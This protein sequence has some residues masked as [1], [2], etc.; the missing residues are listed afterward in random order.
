MRR[1]VELLVPV[2]LA[3]GAAWPGAPPAALGTAVLAALA[4]ALAIA[5]WRL[6]ARL[7]PGARLATRLSAATVLATVLATVPATVL[8][9]FGLLRPWAFLLWAALL[10]LGASRLGGTPPPRPSPGPSEADDPRLPG[11]RAAERALAILALVV[12]ACATVAEVRA[13]RYSAPGTFGFDDLSYHLTTV[14]T[15]AERGDL[16]MVKY[17]VGDDATPYYPIASELVSWALLAPFETND[18]A[19]RWSQLPFALGA[20]AALASLGGR[21]GM[22]PRSVLPALVLFWSLDRT[23]PLLALAASNDASTAFLLLAAADGALELARRRAA[24]PAVYAGAAAGLLLG[25]KYAALLL[26]PLPVGL[27]AVARLAGRQGPGAGRSLL[28]ELAAAGVAAVSGGYTYLRNLVTAGNPVFPAPVTVAGFELFPGREHGGL[29][30]R[31]ALPEAAIDLPEFLFRGDLWG[32][33]APWLLLPAALLAPLAALLAAPVAGRATGDGGEAA[34]PDR[35]WVEVALLAFPALSFLIFLYLM[36]DHRDIRYFLGGITVAALGWGYL[37]DRLERVGW[38]VA[39][40]LASVLRGAT[41]A[42]LAATVALRPAPHATRPGLWFLAGAVLGLLAAVRWQR[43]RRGLGTLAAHPGRAVA[44]ATLVALPLAA[45]VAAR[46]PGRKLEH[47]P[48]PRFVEEHLAGEEGTSL[49]YVG[50]NSPYLYFGSRLQNRVAIVPSMWGLDNRF[51]EWGGTTEVPFRRR[52]KYRPW[53]WNLE[54]LGVTH[55]IVYGLG[56][57]DPERTWMVNHPHRFRQIAGQGTEE[58]WELLPP[59]DEQNP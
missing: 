55:V 45:H 24:G 41:Y 33:V 34:P 19:A 47:H 6:A 1:G 21:L 56:S 28:P 22:R 26:A 44:A 11:V 7:L 49:A 10:A 15:W 57:E 51:Y 54:A 58:I 30:W 53:L 25:T 52:G 17:A 50:L 42:A 43:V 20:L 59:P 8:G 9:H 13:A 37:T 12:L 23:F 29:A 46:Y 48:M 14:A 40:T 3:V 4:A 16:A 31:H 39:A 38:A 2:L 18:V 32:P 36:Y 5:G 35:R 27:Y